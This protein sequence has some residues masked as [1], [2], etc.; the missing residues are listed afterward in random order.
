MPETRTESRPTPRDC[1]GACNVLPEPAPA[2]LLLWDATRG[3]EYSLLLL[4]E[5]WDEDTVRRLLSSLALE[6]GPCMAELHTHCDERDDRVSRF[7]LH[8]DRAVAIVE[9]VSIPA[10]VWRP[11]VASLSTPEGM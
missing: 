9:G 6:A 10:S 7:E 2:R 4:V 3:L 5:P 8:G 1:K 11:A